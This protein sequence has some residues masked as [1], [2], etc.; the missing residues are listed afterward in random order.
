CERRAATALLALS[1]RTRPLDTSQKR[2]RRGTASPSRAL[3]AC[4]VRSGRSLFCHR[5]PHPLPHAQRRLARL[6]LHNALPGAPRVELVRLLDGVAAGGVP[7]GNAA[8]LRAPAAGVAGVVLD[9]GGLAD[10]H[11]PGEF[12]LHLRADDAGG[13]RAELHGRLTG[14]GAKALAR[15]DE[16]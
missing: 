4:K 13:V 3:L 15:R 14:L 7:V 2:P 10:R 11:P 9:D 5:N 1:F 16:E 8:H 12:L 6:P